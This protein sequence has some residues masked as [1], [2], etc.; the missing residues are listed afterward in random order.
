MYV[1]G[2]SLD[3]W[4]LM[5]LTLAVG[6]VVD[7]A[8]V[9]LETIVR[10]MEMGKPPLKAAFGGPAEVG[11]TILSMTISLVA[12]FIPILFLGGIIGRLFHEF[13]V[14]IA[15]AILMSGVVSLTLTPMLSSRVLRAHGHQEHG[16][17]YNATERGWEAM[18]GFYARTLHWVMGHRRA[19][20][21][22]SALILVGTG[23]LFVLV[24]K[25]FIPSQD[26]GNLFITTE[27]AQG[28]SFQDMIA[29]QRE[30]ASIVQ[31]DPHIQGFMSA[32]GGGGGAHPSLNQGR[33]FIGLK[34][35]D[36]RKSVD[37]IIA[38]LRPKLS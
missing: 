18:L 37:E 24:P 14:V 6:F 29:H 4:S 9:M 21:A 30:V 7:D 12:V 27:A 3:N 8:I 26:N 32:V 11:F 31:Q 5:A 2:Y 17:F 19:M 25:G 23:I 22:F 36:Q 13:A 15:V 1:L 16:K 28:T 34:P 33:L 38:E 35:R 10:H 20:L